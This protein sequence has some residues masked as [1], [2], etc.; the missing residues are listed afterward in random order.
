MLPVSLDSP[1]ALLWSFLRTMPSL[2]SFLFAIALAGCVSALGQ[3][4]LQMPPKSTVPPPLPALPHRTLDRI[5]SAN[6]VNCG[7]VK[8]E[9]DYTR[10]EDHGNRAAFDVDLCKA[11]A[12]AVL[13][14]G[15]RLVVKSYPDE[16][17]AVRMLQAGEVDLLA[18]A[19]LSVANMTN[20]VALSAPVLLDGQSVLFPKSAAIHHAS[21]LA[22]KKICFLTGS[23]AEG[24]LHRYAATHGVRFVW[25]PF[26]EAGE[27]EA[28]F[29]T[30]NCDAVTGDRTQLAN[31]RGIEAGRKA[32]FTILPEQMRED[33]LAM[34]TWAGDPNFSALVYWTVQ[35]LLNAEAMGLSRA[36]MQPG[37]GAN[38]S[39]DAV[40]LLGQRFG[41][42]AALGTRAHWGAEVLAAVGNYGELYERD[43]G[44]ASPM[45]LERGDN[46]LT[47][48]GGALYPVPLRDR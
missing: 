4:A 8:E 14:P 37:K 20:A 40:E 13:G 10:T 38:L 24:G 46:R 31:I 42:S 18:S 36:D 30:G 25:Y 19:S 39:P 1:F 28:A 43:L 23:A 35:L 29:F 34:A 27:M 15:A 7:V 2:R 11:V 12:I 33:P 22:G 26:S 5:H 44:P 9:E 41:A 6:A 32:A 16:P 17:F 48:H 47:T 45:G 21:D 3:Q